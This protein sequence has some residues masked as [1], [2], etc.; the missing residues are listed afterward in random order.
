MSQSIHFVI[1]IAL[2]SVFTKCGVFTIGPYGLHI[3]KKINIQ[4][5]VNGSRANV[6]S[7]SVSSSTALHSLQCLDPGTCACHDCPVEMQY[8]FKNFRHVLK[9][10]H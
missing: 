1:S 3:M 8:T 9:Y 10:I 2:R 4:F 7:G 5:F 6:I